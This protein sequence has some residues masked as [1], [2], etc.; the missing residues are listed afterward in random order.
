[1]A[2]NTKFNLLKNANPPS[3]IDIVIEKYLGHKFSTSCNQIKD[4]ANVYYF[5]LPCIGE[6]LQLILV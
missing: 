6:M 5:N 1:M 3:L 4:I 2:K